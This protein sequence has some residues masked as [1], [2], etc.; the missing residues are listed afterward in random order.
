[1]RPVRTLPAY[2]LFFPAAV[3]YALAAVPVWALEYAGLLPASSA[4]GWA[5]WHGHEML[6]GYGLAV[7]GGYLLTKISK[8]AL[9]TVFGLWL[10]GRVAYLVL[11]LPPLAGAI[12]AISFPAALLF[13]AGLPFLRAA[14]KGRNLIFAGILAALVLAALA[15]QSGAAGA[16]AAGEA[17]GT[18][19]GIDMLTLLMFTMG[20]RVIAA[21]SSG[22]LRLRG[23]EIFNPAQPRFEA[24]GVTAIIVLAA[25]EFWG[26]APLSSAAAALVGAVAVALRLSG[27][28][29]WKTRDDAALA[30]LHLGYAWIGI[31][32]GVKAASLA[33]G[34]PSEFDAL[35][36][37]MVGALGTL[38]LAMMARV[39]LQRS[40]RAIVFPGMLMLAVMAMSGAAA[41]R[42]LAAIPEF[43]LAL[44]SAA[45]LF[46]VC[47]F[48][49]F[50]TFLFPL[51]RPK[52]RGP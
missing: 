21:A 20:G 8:A 13:Y 41:C 32:L 23:A 35:H 5:S 11:P 18:S 39:A 17:R 33:L 27:W 24:L 10:L 43:R 29:V 44:V 3:L 7:V 15:Y 25:L 14:K 48:L 4:G 9:L 6:F 42:L 34:V 12:I 16:L 45:S 46:W 51:L 19:L 28:R 30:A 49:L 40:Q 36:G 47:A 22:A 2:R 50:A 1:M 26:G 38:S 31:G 37:V 52:G